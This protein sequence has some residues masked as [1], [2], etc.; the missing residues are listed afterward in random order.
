[1]RD[2][3]IFQALAYI[4]IAPSWR[5]DTWSS[6]PARRYQA[7]HTLNSIY[8]PVSDT[9]Q[10]SNFQQ[11]QISAPGAMPK[12]YARSWRCR[13]F[14]STRLE[15]LRIAATTCTLQKIALRNHETFDLNSYYKRVRHRFGSDGD[16]ERK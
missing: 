9:M 1:M 11:A 14:F 5:C 13:P 10:G 7:S 2:V 4:V 8:G 3:L 15:V 12:D 6:P 16:R